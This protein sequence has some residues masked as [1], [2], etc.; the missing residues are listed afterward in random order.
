MKL[1]EVKCPRCG[2]NDISVA[3]CCEGL[4]HYHYT[5][6]AF[7]ARKKRDQTPSPQSPHCEKCHTTLYL[8][9]EATAE[10]L[11]KMR[12]TDNINFRVD[13]CSRCGAET[14]SDYYCDECGILCLECWGKPVPESI[15]LLTPSEIIFKIGRFNDSAYKLC[16]KCTKDLKKWKR[17]R[18]N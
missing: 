9:K 4:L 16:Q 17:G 7:T 15:M 10:L 3:M 1:K 12:D 11:K 14:F 18:P 8:D 2:G 5:K 6:E 13:L